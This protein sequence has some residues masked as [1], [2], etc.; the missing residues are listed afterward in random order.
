MSPSCT[1]IVD[2]YRGSNSPLHRISTGR[3]G[4]E[5]PPR[6][7]GGGGAGTSPSMPS[8]VANISDG[9]GGGGALFAT[10]VSAT[11]VFFRGTPSNAP[12]DMRYTMRPAVSGAAY[13]S[14]VSSMG[15]VLL[16]FITSRTR[17]LPTR[18]GMSRNFCGTSNG[19]PGASSCARLDTS[20]SELY[21][22]TSA[23]STARAESASTSVESCLSRSASMSLHASFL[24]GRH[25][26][27]AASSS[28][29]SD[30]RTSSALIAMAPNGF[31]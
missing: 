9:G 13:P 6:R 5:F 25:P 23:R 29:L 12:F 1:S 14:S 31:L 30:V 28:P 7:A 17:A 2:L 4:S 22:A 18:R 26:D 11:A 16:S 20:S 27:R 8:S 15:F 10:A 21:S 24:S 3:G 19:K